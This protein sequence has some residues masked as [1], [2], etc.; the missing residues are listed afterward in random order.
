MRPR[1]DQGVRHYPRRAVEK[2][3]LAIVVA[4]LAVVAVMVVVANKVIATM[5]QLAAMSPAAW[6]SALT[7]SFCAMSYSSIFL[8]D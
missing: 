3:L 8:C 2:A 5:G 6:S 7:G 1:S 4:V